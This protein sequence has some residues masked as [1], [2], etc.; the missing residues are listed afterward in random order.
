MLI[1]G[2]NAESWQHVPTLTTVT[3]KSASIAL[4]WLAHRRTSDLDGGR[5]VRLDEYLAAAPFTVPAATIA[6]RTAPG[7]ALPPAM[8]PPPA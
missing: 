3:V 4:P 2:A 8:T 5:A 7:F 1:T 6:S